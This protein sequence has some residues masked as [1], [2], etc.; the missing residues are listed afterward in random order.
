MVVFFIVSDYG[1]FFVSYFCF[2]AWFI[3]MI[4]VSL[5]GILVLQYHNKIHSY[6]YIIR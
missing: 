6:I 3:G 4:I 5:V 2:L 1:S